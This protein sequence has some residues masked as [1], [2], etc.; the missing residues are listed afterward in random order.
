[1][2]EQVVGSN[3]AH[4]DSISEKPGTNQRQRDRPNLI[5]ESG[6]MRLASD[7]TLRTNDAAA[8][9][10]LTESN[11]PVVAEDGIPITE[12][13]GSNSGADQEQ[14]LVMPSSELSVMALPN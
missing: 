3:P 13:N 10:M 7:K 11:M 2:I 4:N 12:Q 14:L 9:R 5:E 6:S 8:S 1:M